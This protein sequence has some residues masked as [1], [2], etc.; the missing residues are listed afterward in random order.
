MKSLGD[1]NDIFQMNSHIPVITNNKLEQI[2]K[3]KERDVGT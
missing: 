1:F 3:A 2:G